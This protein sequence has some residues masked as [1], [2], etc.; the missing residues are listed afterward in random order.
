MSENGRKQSYFE[1][2]D[3]RL[4]PKER[5]LTRNSARVHL[6][7]LVL[8]LLIALVEHQ[9]ELVSK[10]WLLETVWAGRFVEDG[11]LN[12]TIS[13]LRKNLG[14]QQNGSDMIETVPKVGYRFI[15]AVTEV[16]PT[17][18]SQPTH[19]QKQKKPS[20]IWLL[21]LT[22]AILLSV[23]AWYFLGPQ[24]PVTRD[25]LT[26]LTNNLAEDEVPEWSPDGKKIAF[27]S[28]RD[29][30]KNIYVMNADGSNVVRLTDGS[31]AEDVPVWSPDGT[32]IL[33]G[34]MRD[35]N[36]EIYIMNA[37]G[38]EQKRLTF[39]SVVDGGPAR[40]SPDGQ[41]IVFSRS[42]ANEGDAYYNFDIYTMNVDGSDVRQLT[43]DPEY[44]AGPHWSPDGARIA[45]LSARDK[46]Y[47]VFTMN[48]DGSDQ[49]NLTKDKAHQSPNGWTPDSKQIFYN[50][51]P[52][53]QGASNQLGL[54][55]ADGSN[56][57]LITSF[58]DKTFHISYSAVAGKMVFSLTKDGNYEI[59]T[60][61]AGSLLNN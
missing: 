20:P 13:T 27:T 60:M 22:G 56:R 50:A 39:N 47:D 37:D 2:D 51:Q 44:D 49:V 36:L 21:S 8:D 31:T 5:L 59:Y 41:K 6:T 24:R 1:F 46:N 58:P 19:T 32:K 7:P 15:A 54:M 26:R 57:R 61:E 28:N 33:F 52:T 25:G 34:S 30:A 38:S 17:V 55:N 40:F 53:Q 18:A 10:E 12:R 43:F 42:A 23:A 3:F 35:G 14:P 11:N 48:P 4:Y 9:G 45:F 16:S 29:G